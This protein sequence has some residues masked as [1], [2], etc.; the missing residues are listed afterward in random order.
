MGKTRTVSLK[1]RSISRVL[2]VPTFHRVELDSR[3]GAKQ[4]VIIA[5]STNNEDLIQQVEWDGVAR[6]APW[7][8]AAD[9]CNGGQLDFTLG[10]RPSSWAKNPSTPPLPF[11][12]GGVTMPHP[13]L[14][15]FSINGITLSLSARNGSPK[16]TRTLLQTSNVTLPLK[17]MGDQ[18]HRHL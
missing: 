2:T 4:L 17:P 5:N 8:L 12:G 15:G 13:V 1:I 10:P 6:V 14:T 11:Q 3:R 16:G 9:I 7:L 18:L